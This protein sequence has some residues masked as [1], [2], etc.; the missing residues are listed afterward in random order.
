MPEDTGGLWRSLSSMG[1]TSAKLL[2]DANDYR[3]C[4]NRAYYAAYHVLTGISIERGDNF[5]RGWNNP[6]HEQ[7]PDL[8]RNNGDLSVSSRRQIGHQL[9]YLRTV[10][11]DAD[12][13]PGRTVDRA[14]A[15]ICLR[16]AANIL[17]LSGVE[18]T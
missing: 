14:I 16:Y 2:F 6:S 8:I 3:G 1:L 9:T 17:Y 11:E 5:V 4:A 12:Y 18:E 13:R 7:L 10:R 15:L